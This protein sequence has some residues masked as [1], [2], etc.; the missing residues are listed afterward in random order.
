VEEGH[1][2]HKEGSRSSPRNTGPLLPSTAGRPITTGSVD[3]IYISVRGIIV[4]NIC[5]QSPKC[6]CAERHSVVDQGT[7]T[8]FLRVDTAATTRTI[9]IEFWVD[10]STSWGIGAVLE[11]EWRAWKLAPGWNEASKREIGWAEMLAIE[12][13]LRWAIEEGI[14]DTHLI[15]RSDNMG[16][17]GA[18]KGGKSR[19][20]EQNRV[21]QRIVA[22]MRLHGIWITSQYVPS[23]QNRA[24]APSRGKPAEGAREAVGKLELPL[25]IRKF[26]EN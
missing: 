17:I 8:R 4:V 20:L 3:K 14:K 12:L 22:I 10:A 19:N 21:L 15:V 26:V 11:E 23:S 9:P 24:D 25:C 6:G 7:R 1:A 18:L 16:V 2:L 13:G 5:D